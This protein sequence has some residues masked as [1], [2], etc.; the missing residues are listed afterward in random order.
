M[1]FMIPH[2]HFVLICYNSTCLGLNILAY[3]CSWADGKVVSP[4]PR[5][6]LLPPHPPGDTPDTHFCNRLSRT[7]G[8]SHELYSTWNFG[9]MIHSRGN[10]SYWGE[11]C[12]ISTLSI[13]NSVWAAPGF[14]LIFRGEKTVSNAQAMAVPVHTLTEA[15]EPSIIRIRLGFTKA[16]NPL[17][18]FYFKWNG[19]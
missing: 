9:R 4:M 7:Q 5:P 16:V 17:R 15:L 10:S 3:S 6:P 19:T 8:F 1:G 12:P 18:A 11:I 13:K 2:Q 14:N